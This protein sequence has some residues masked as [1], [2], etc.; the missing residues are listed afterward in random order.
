MLKQTGLEYSVPAR[1]GWTIV[2]VGMLVPEAHEIFVCAAGCLR[3]VVLSAAEMNLTDRFSTVAIEEHNVTDGDM[4]E[5]LVEGVTDIL[6]RLKKRPPCVL[7]YTSCIHHFMGTDL[8]DC[9]RILSDRFPDVDFVDCYMTP[10]MRKS[11]LNPDK[12]MRKRLYAAIKPLKT[13]ERDVLLCGNCFSV[14]DTSDIKV[15]LG[16]A[17][18][19]LL[20]LPSVDNYS[21]YKK[22]GSAGLI[23]S[24]LSVAKD[25]AD[26]LAGKLG[27]KSLQLPF[28][29]G[30]EEIRDNLCKLANEI[31]TTYDTFEVDKARAE[32]ALVK[33]MKVIGECEIAVDGMI[34]TRPYSL[35]RLLAE[36]G[37]NITT[38]FSDSVGGE[39]TDYE[40]LKTNVKGIRFE[41][42]ISPEMRTFSYKSTVH[43]NPLGACGTNTASNAN[44]I[45]PAKLL[46]LGQ[47]AAY[48]TQTPYFVDMV[49]NG[50]LYG[51]DGIVELSRM[52]TDAFINVKD[53][54]KTLD[55]KG[56]GCESCI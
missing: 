27:V 3:G 19:R 12:M 48:F 6:N 17:G 43:S 28:S 41:K 10:T 31:G 55:I 47:K 52:M 21:D 45:I 13:D 18:K 14:S 56:W 36:H 46:A 35:A 2:H 53:L 15:L 42:C 11:T 33:A 29:F 24:N 23:I 25:A 20:E 5:L 40:W 30:Y 51:F 7:I 54:K 49:E 4:E 39:K 37:F 44:N 16:K 50:P 22:L 32:E 8:D 26:E 34:T 1:G 38:V 9:F